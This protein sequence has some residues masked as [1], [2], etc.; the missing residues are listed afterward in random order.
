M[1]EFNPEVKN[2]DIKEMFIAEFCCLKSHIEPCDTIA[3]K[4]QRRKIET[5]AKANF[6]DKA[7]QLEW[8]F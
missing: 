4:K 2:E 8:W 1:H 3:Q 5:S 7:T 6:L